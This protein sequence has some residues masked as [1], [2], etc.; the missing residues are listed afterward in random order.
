[1]LKTWGDYW[2]VRK[3]RSTLKMQRNGWHVRK[4]EAKSC[5]R[6]CKGMIA[7]DI[8]GRGWNKWRSRVKDARGGYKTCVRKMKQLR[9]TLKMQE[10]VTD[11]WGRGPCLTWKMCKDWHNLLLSLSSCE[12][13]IN[14]NDLTIDPFALG[15][16][17]E[18]HHSCNV[19]RFAQ[20]F[21]R[22]LLGQ[23]L[24][25][26]LCFTP[27]EKLCSHRPWCHRIGGDF[28]P[29][30]LLCQ[31]LGEGLHRGFAGS[32]GSVV[33]EQGSDKRGGYVDNAT[34]FSR[35]NTKRRFLAGQES[36]LRIHS[37]DSIPILLRCLHNRRI[38]VGYRSCAV[39][40]D[41]DFAERFFGLIEQWLDRARAAHIPL[42]CDGLAVFTHNLGDDFIGFL[43]VARVVHHH[44]RSLLSQ[45]E[46]NLP[47]NSLWSSRHYGCLSLQRRCHLRSCKKRTKLKLTTTSSS[48]DTRKAKIDDVRKRLYLSRNSPGVITRTGAQGAQSSYNEKPEIYSTKSSERKNLKCRHVWP[49]FLRIFFAWFSNKMWAR[50]TG[51]TRTKF[52]L[53]R[54]K[55]EHKNLGIRCCCCRLVVQTDNDNPVSTKKRVSLAPEDRSESQERQQ[56]TGN[57]RS[58]ATKENGLGTRRKT[59]DRERQNTSSSHTSGR[60]I[61]TREIA[62]FP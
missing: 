36:S 8:C 5:W 39:H 34:T 7:S 56:G 62:V 21:Q 9:I 28:G 51:C 46:R 2:H 58:S 57:H 23:G 52:K 16:D 50:E 38:V 53:G 33:G 24:Y 20:S 59:R 11:M 15:T 47:P 45:V 37:I 3:R 43:F 18:G 49:K 14:S 42:H 44:R 30:E 12:T 61:Q 29:S 19:F 26:R 54:I 35:W 22:R 48:Q 55:N 41:V 1:M 6:R 31:D 60:K 32:V 40:N 25:E 4:M 27:E 17:K 13:A 10:V